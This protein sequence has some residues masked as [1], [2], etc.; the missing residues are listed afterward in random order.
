MPEIPQPDASQVCLSVV[1]PLSV[2]DRVVDW[3]LT[4]PSWKTEFSIHAVAARGPLVRLA[5][6]EERVNGFAN[7]AELKML[8]ERSLLDQM[9]V[10]L[11][12]LMAG[13]DGGY[14]VLPVE[15]FAVFG[16]LG[17]KTECTT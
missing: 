7:R 6:G 13:V 8:M 1:F 12:A 11:E 14:W 10:E 4:H 17:A 16:R 15:R 9:L 2:E 5:S 3:L